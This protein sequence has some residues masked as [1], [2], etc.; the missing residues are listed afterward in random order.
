MAVTAIPAVGIPLL[1]PVR[2]R[3]RSLMPEAGLMSWI[4]V[5]YRPGPLIL[6][7][8]WLVIL[9]HFVATEVFRL[10]PGV[11]HIAARRGALPTGG[12]VRTDLTWVA[13]GFLPGPLEGFFGP[14]SV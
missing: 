9:P 2:A 14:W 8:L 5:F 12:L 4:A 3:P 7:V 11:S 13:A 6:W 1:C 10:P